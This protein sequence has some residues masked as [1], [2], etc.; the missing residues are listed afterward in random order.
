MVSVSLKFHTNVRKFEL[1]SRILLNEVNPITN[2]NDFSKT[3]VFKSIDATYRIFKS[4]TKPE[5]SILLGC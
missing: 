5:Y 4:I 3:I 2:C 1:M